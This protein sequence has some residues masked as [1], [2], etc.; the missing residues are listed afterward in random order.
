MIEHYF[1][2]IKNVDDFDCRSYSMFKYGNRHAGIEFGKSLFESFKEVFPFD[3]SNGNDII[4]T[5]SPYK[6]V[7]PASQV[8]A[9]SFLD[10]LN[11][12]LDSLDKFSANYT[13]I[14]RDMLFEGD[15]GKLTFEERT[16]LMKKDILHIDKEFIEDKYLVIIDDIKITGAHENKILDLL[17]RVDYKNYD[18]LFFLYYAKL[19][20]NINSNI[21]D[22]FNHC[23]VKDIKDLRS[24]LVNRNSYINARICKYILSYKN[25]E[26]YN[27]FLDFMRDYYRDTLEKIYISCVGDGYNKM[28]IYRE[29]FELLKIKLGKQNVNRI[30][31]T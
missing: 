23:I 1:K 18:K 24:I 5:S 6:Y 30:K 28:G 27:S 7:P 17:N 9:F 4:V 10:Q 15:Y 14:S 13:K 3:K 2:S 21:E 29:N 8:I 12:H 26:E 11:L 19:E 25:K 31:T 22:Y 16:D 20:A